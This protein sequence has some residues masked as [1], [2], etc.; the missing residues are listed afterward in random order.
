VGRA[1]SILGAQRLHESHLPRYSH[2]SLAYPFQSTDKFLFK[3]LIKKQQ[4]YRKEPYFIDKT[5]NLIT[6]S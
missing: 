4:F 6:S 3:K 2:R 1:V 5:I